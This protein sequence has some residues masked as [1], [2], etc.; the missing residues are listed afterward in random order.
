MRSRVLIEPGM[1]AMVPTAA[2]GQHAFAAY[3]RG[4][5]GTF[6]AHAIQVLTVEA[7]MLTRIVSFNDSELFGSF[8]LPAGHP[9]A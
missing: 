7:G 4:P 9:A 3:V 1:F 6:G 5:D 2:N 8:G